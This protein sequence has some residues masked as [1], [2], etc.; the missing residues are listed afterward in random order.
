M[1]YIYINRKER[2]KRER[3]E[4][5]LMERDERYGNIVYIGIMSIVF[6]GTA[7][8]MTMLLD[9]LAI[10]WKILF[11]I[12]FGGMGVLGLPPRNCP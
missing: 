4:R 2:R 9:P 12:V 10:G 1:I 6:F 7:S 3:E 5:E 8:F 11:V